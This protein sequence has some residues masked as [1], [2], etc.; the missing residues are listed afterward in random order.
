MLEEFDF[1]TPRRRP[2]KQS[3]VGRVVLWLIA[4][5]WTALV[6]ACIVAGLARVG[7]GPTMPDGAIAVLLLFG[8]F[9]FAVA[10]AVDQ[11][12]FAGRR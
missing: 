10:F 7:D 8:L 5:M 4:C 12:V 9:G 2:P 11:M 3:G 1:P 6:S